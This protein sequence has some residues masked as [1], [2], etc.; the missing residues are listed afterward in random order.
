VIYLPEGASDEVI[1]RITRQM[2][3]AAKELGAM[4][5]GGR[6]EYTAGIERPMVAVTALGIAR[7]ESIVR[8]EGGIS[9]DLILMTKTA[10]IEGTSILASDFEDELRAKGVGEDI[11]SRAKEFTRYISVVRE[12]LTLTENAHPNSMHDPT[13]GGVIAG[14]L[15]MAYASKKTFIVYEDRIK[16][17]KETAILAK[18]LSID[19]LRLISSATL[20]ATIPPSKANE[21]LRALKRIGVD[22][23]V[24]GIVKDREED[25]LLILKRV[26][27]V[28]EVFRD[29]YVILIACTE[30]DMHGS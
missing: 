26:D 1:D 12:A 8:T 5:I 2:D 29:V 10:G 24:I 13:E 28:I 6:T 21:A 19:P 25:K 9:G 7:K 3:S 17:A 4:I 20:L 15:E 14:L 11:L 27:G 18:V 23:S 16:I 30:H 22:A